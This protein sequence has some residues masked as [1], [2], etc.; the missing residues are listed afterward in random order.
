MD[1]RRLCSSHVSTL[2]SGSGQAPLPYR[3]ALYVARVLHA[4]WKRAG[5]SASSCARAACTRGSAYGAVR[6]LALK[7]TENS[8]PLSRMRSRA[9]APGFPM[10]IPRSCADRTRK[11]SVARCASSKEIASWRDATLPERNASRTKFAAV[12]RM[13]GSE[14]KPARAPSAASFAR[15]CG[16]ATSR[17][18]TGSIG[19]AHPKRAFNRSRKALQYSGAPPRRVGGSGL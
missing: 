15:Q 9:G 13:S 2:Q 14:V 7:S 19:S 16:P 6:S 12:S 8:E 1:A 5:A 18:R 10:V 3:L 17:R 11:P 4:I